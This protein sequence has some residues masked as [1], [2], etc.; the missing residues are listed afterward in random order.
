[1]AEPQSRAEKVEQLRDE[2]DKRPDNAQWE[3]LDVGG[4]LEMTRK[5][6]AELVAIAERRASQEVDET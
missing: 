4:V 2:I 3:V 6:H 5:A 1:M